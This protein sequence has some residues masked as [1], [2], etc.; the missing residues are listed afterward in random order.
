MV[1][2]LL[3]SCAPAPPEEEVSPAEEEAVTEEGEE[4]EP[5]EEEEESTMPILT[6]GT[7]R[8]RL[9]ATTFGERE[10]EFASQ[11]RETS[12][13]WVVL[14]AE[15]ENLSGVSLIK[16]WYQE[17]KGGETSM[18]ETFSIEGIANVYVIDSQGSMHH[19]VKL[20]RSQITFVVP[21]DG[22]GFTL[23]FLDCAPIELGY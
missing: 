20:S 9:K 7:H 2:L 19:A 14:Q 18:I 8:W 12:E 13:G 23:H 22:H 21:S 6:D 15:F 10:V 11:V 17:T 4:V 1:V 16:A 3:T 5:P